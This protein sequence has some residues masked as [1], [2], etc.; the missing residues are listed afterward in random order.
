MAQGSFG[1]EFPWAPFPFP[2]GG[3][4]AGHFPEIIV[5]PGSPRERPTVPVAMVAC[6]RPGEHPWKRPDIPC[7]KVMDAGLSVAVDTGPNPVGARA[8]NL[9]QRIV[10]H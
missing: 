4:W 5:L 10:S 9:C 7:P 1:P 8:I 2:S 3:K 6:L